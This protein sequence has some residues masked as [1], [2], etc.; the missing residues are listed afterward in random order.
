L[1]EGGSPDTG[2]TPDVTYTQGT[3]ADLD[4]NLLASDAGG[5]WWNVQWLNRTKITFNNTNSAE[6]LL[7]FPVLG[8]ADIR[9]VD[10]DGTPLDYEIEAWDDTPGSESAKVWV[11]VPRIDAGS[12]T[13]FIHLYYNNTGASSAENATRVAF[14]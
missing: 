13:D 9:F 1:T 4:T 10:G 7:N 6:D 11:K 12:T 14:E 2:A 3:L 8:G 5:A